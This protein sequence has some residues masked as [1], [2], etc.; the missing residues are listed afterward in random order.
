M[1]NIILDTNILLRYPRVLGLQL[2]DTIFLIPLE[3]VEELAFRANR[4]GANFDR[5]IDL[6][7]RAAA[8]GTVSLINTDLPGFRMY[9]EVLSSPKLGGAD[10]AILTTALTYKDK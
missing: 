2:P 8:Q 6:I 5:R 3:V 1:T 9:E 7:N 4:R 10:R